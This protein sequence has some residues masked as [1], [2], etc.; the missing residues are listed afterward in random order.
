MRPVLFELSTISPLA[1]LVVFA[2]IVCAMGIWLAVLRAKRIYTKDHL[3]TGFAVTAMATI[4]LLLINRMGHFRVNAYGAMLM[5]GFVVGLISATHLGRRRG[6]SAESLLDLG[7]LI[8]LSAIVGARVMY[9]IITPG[10]GPILDIHEVLSNGLGG[11]SFHGGFLGGLLATIIYVRVKKIH[12][13]RLTDCLAPGVA[14]GYAITRIGCFLNGCCFGKAC[15]LPWAVV[16]PNLHDGT[17][18]HPSQLY[19]SAMAMA[20]FG[21]LLFLSRGKSLGRA[22][23]LTMVFF[24]LEGIE[25]FTME[26]FRQPDPTGHGVLTA[27]QIV[28]ILLAITG[29]VGWF[30]LAQHPA[31]E[32]A[33]TVSTAKTP[34][35]SANK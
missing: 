23:R 6:I 28:S 32:A 35:T 17:P 18:R 16:F 8:L 21:L 15:H 31:V 13:W 9:W 22:G 34:P 33:S 3:V 10:A 1:C 26:I 2:V 30:L 24:V 5:I 14:I 20:M 27:A 11:L 25:R 7:L 19:A 12:F 29:I 4:L